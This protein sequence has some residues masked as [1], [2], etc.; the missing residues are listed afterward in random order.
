MY[1]TQKVR[2]NRGI[3]PKRQ[4]EIDTDVQV[5]SSHFQMM[6][7]PKSTHAYSSCNKYNYH[8]HKLETSAT[9]LTDTIQT[10]NEEDPN[11]EHIS[12]T[13]YFNQI[14]SQIYEESDTNLIDQQSK[15]INSLPKNDLIRYSS[16]FG[17]YCAQS[18]EKKLE[19]SEAITLHHK[20]FNT[21]FMEDFKKDAIEL[22]ESFPEQRNIFQE[23]YSRIIEEKMQSQ[24]PKASKS[25]YLID[26][27]H[28]SG[29]KTSKNSQTLALKAGTT[30]YDTN[31]ITVSKKLNF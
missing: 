18:S 14:F 21:G 19:N 24:T 26:E 10:Y 16:D 3:K 13:D 30:N 27:N 29:Y 2:E 6:N 28:W 1:E 8:K 17:I 25:T 31:S 4:L 5:T 20:E 15:Q 7:F 12:Y 9:D 23:F 22:E 11:G